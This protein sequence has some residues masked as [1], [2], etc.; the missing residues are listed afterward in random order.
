MW[1]AFLSGLSCAVGFAGFD[2]ADFAVDGD[3]GV[4]EAVEFAAVFGF[5]GLDHEGAG[6]GPGHGGGVETV[7]H[8]ALGD[9]LD[10]DAGGVLERAEVEDAF[11]GD[12][13]AAAL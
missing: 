6:D 1:G 9:V 2:G 12:E 10:A 13:A 5:G 3:E 11:V 8:E 7:V 4:A